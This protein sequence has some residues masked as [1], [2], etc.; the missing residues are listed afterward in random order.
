MNLQAGTFT[1]H[2]TLYGQGLPNV[3]VSDLHYVPLDPNTGKGNLV[4]AG[5]YGR[6]AWT[7]PNAGTS[8][9]A[10]PVSVGIAATNATIVLRSDPVK[11]SNAQL[12]VNNQ[13]EMEQPW[14]DLPQLTIEAGI[15]GSFDTDTVDIQ[16]A[17]TTT[18]SS[19]YV[20]NVNVNLGGGVY[21]VNVGSAGN[22]MSTINGTV[23]ISSDPSGSDTLLVNDQ[24][25]PT[26][27]DAKIEDMANNSGWGSISGFGWEGMA[28]INYQNR[29]R[30]V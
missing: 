18:G 21:T 23:S 28:H 25:D 22:D 2:W 4:L 14:A 27:R 6:G 12:L 24:G 3:R 29:A 17:G 5:T 15:A 26:R 1:P 7:I 9:A 8:L 10:P 20:T 11:S 13:L 19:T 30:S 16:N